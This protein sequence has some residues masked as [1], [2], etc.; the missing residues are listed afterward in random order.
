VIVE[1]QE[2]IAHIQT[3]IVLTVVTTRNALNYR[4]TNALTKMV[5]IPT[6]TVMYLAAVITAVP[7]EEVVTQIASRNIV[8]KTL[9]VVAPVN[10]VTLISM[11]AQGVRIRFP[12]G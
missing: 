9:I 12:H 11:N 7:V 3:R 4:N 1:R 5:V 6:K 10:A 2:R 8:T